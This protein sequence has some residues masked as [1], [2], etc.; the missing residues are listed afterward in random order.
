MPIASVNH[1]QSSRVARWT[2]PARTAFACGDPTVT[3]PSRRQP[4]PLRHASALVV[5]QF[6]GVVIVLAGCSSDPNSVASQAQAGDGKGYIAGDGRVQQLTVAER[7]TTVALS[8]VTVDGGTWSMAQDGQGKVVVINVWGSWC[9]PCVEETPQLQRVWSSLEAAGK[10]VAFVGI[11]IKEGPA[12]AAAFIRANGVTYPSI[13]D[14]ASGGQPVLAL[15]GRAPATPSTVV[16]DRQ[17]RIAARVLGATTA[18]TL[19]AL[20]ND[21]IAE[22]P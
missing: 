18:S 1:P 22:Q 17:G 21:V 11:N 6:L 5:A 15:Q 4:R 13:S 8:G 3:W 19:T 16:L 14:S 10:P 12:T 2:A 7:T 20:I 9:P